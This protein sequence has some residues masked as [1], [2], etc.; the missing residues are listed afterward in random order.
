MY[1]CE[2]YENHTF[3]FRQCLV[4]DRE[5]KSASF[6]LENGMIYLKGGQCIHNLV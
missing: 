2:G 4:W 3:F 1:Q 5:Q 6:G